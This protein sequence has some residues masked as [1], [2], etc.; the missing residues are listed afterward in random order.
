MKTSCGIS[1][2]PNSALLSSRDLF[3]GSSHP[4][5]LRCTNGASFNGSRSLK[6][7]PG[8]KRR[9]DKITGDLRPYLVRQEGLQPLTTGRSPQFSSI[10]S[11]AMKASCGI[12]TL[13]NW[14]IFFLPLLLLLEQLALS[15][16]VAAVA[17]G[18]HVLAQRP[19]GLA[20][21]D[22]PPIAACI[23]IWNRCG[24]IRSFSFS[25]ID[26]PRLSARARCTM[27][28]SASTGSALTRIDS[29]HEVV[30]LVA[31]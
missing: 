31:D 3:P 28:D 18:D 16:D 10:F 17:L 9:D 23:G 1:T 5:G 24:G 4:P 30:L 26:R 12:S 8:H 6:L 25:H 2:L 22:L 14:R 19:D 7:D 13:P 27:M 29:L 11:A 15:R 21:D 20:R